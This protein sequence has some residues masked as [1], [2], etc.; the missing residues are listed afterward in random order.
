M[1][2]IVPFPGV[3]TNLSAPGTDRKQFSKSPYFGQSLPQL[4]E[5]SLE[6]AL[7][8]LLATVFMHE[9]VTIEPDTPFVETL[10][11]CAGG[12]LRRQCAVV[13]RRFAI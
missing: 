4:G 9:Q 8:I 10:S 5:C 3:G 11:E 1:V 7:G 13:S 2:E 12:R 6:A